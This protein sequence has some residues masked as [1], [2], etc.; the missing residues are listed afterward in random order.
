MLATPS[1]YLYLLNVD[2]STNINLT[3]NQWVRLEARAVPAD[4]N[5]YLDS[6][7]VSPSRQHAEVW[8][9]NGKV[10]HGL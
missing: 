7:V 10:S 4:N 1:I 2:S 6:N 9:E 8:E 3:N 5:V